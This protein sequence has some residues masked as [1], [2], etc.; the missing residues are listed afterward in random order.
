MRIT[1]LG[2]IFVLGYT[3]TAWAWGDEDN[4]IVLYDGSWVC[5][6]PDAYETAIE[7][8]N[9]TD[10]SFRELKKDLIDQKLCIYIEGD[11]IEDM[12]APYVIIVDQQ[13]TKV[14]V[15]FTIEFYKKFKF[16]HRRITRVTF[17]GWTEE[18]QL[19]EYYDWFNNG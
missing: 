9:N 17:T 4:P 15:K 10:K 19:R 5:S 14:K 11:D 18:A 2:L 6:T 12:M 8:E 13:A 16:L 1:L 7:M 3:I